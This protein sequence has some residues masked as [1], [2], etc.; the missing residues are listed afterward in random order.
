MDEPLWESLKQLNLC[1]RRVVGLVG[2]PFSHGLQGARS[3]NLP[4]RFEVVCGSRIC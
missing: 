1:P 2:P 4:K 3:R